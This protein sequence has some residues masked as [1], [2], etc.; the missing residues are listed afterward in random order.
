M[1]PLGAKAT[2]FAVITA[3]LVA[4]GPPQLTEI[5]GQSFSSVTEFIESFS[6]GS[7]HLGVFPSWGSEPP[8]IDDA[9]EALEMAN[10]L[11][12]SPEQEVDRAV[13]AGK[14]WLLVDADGFV[15]AAM[16]SVGASIQ[17]CY[18]Y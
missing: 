4:C 17:G 2:V 3:L 15:F 1:R 9:A 10:G 16:E 12:A 7:E 5:E 11:L 18:G 6:C 8:V 14:V 13:R